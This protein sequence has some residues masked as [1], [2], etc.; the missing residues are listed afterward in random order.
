MAMRYGFMGVVCPR[1]AVSFGDAG[2]ESW[3]QPRR[4]TPPHLIPHSW[5][6]APSFL[7]TGRTGEKKTGKIAHFYRHM[8]NLD[9]KSFK[10]TPRETC[11][12]MQAGTISPIGRL[13]STSGRFWPVAFPCLWIATYFYSPLLLQ[14]AAIIVSRHFIFPS[15][16]FS[17]LYIQDSAMLSRFITPPCHG[18]SCWHVPAAQ[19]LRAPRSRQRVYPIAPYRKLLCQRLS[20]S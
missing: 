16:F 20:A 18:L 15:N 4:H 1:L 6:Q 3:S 17:L 11:E 14:G 2:S 5:R 9:L 12:F 8:R 19:H 13:L 10:I 7:G